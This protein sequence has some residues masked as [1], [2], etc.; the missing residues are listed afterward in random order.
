MAEHIDKRFHTP[1]FD[2]LVSRANKWIVFSAARPGQGG[3]GHIS[4]RP[5]LEWRAEFEQRGCV[6]DS[7]MTA[8]ARTMSDQKNINHQRNVQVLAPL[9]EI[10]TC[11]NWRIGRNPI[12][13]IF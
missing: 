9:I 11:W 13:Q 6:F 3:H 12:W 2:F 7:K 5:E 8:V 1:F 10:E 4:E